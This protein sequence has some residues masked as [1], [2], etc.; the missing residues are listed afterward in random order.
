MIRSVLVFG[1]GSAGFLAAL[2]LKS[3]LPDLPV[4]VLRSKDVGIIQVGE[5]TT[6]TFGFHLHHFCGLDLKTFY[7]VAQ[8]Q[9]K[10]GIRFEWGPRTFFNYAFGVELDSRYALLP[11]GTGYYLDNTEPFD[12]TGVQSILM[13][14]NKIWLRNP[15]GSPRIVSDEFTYHLENEKLVNYFEHIAQERGIPIVD[16]TAI[17]VLQDDHG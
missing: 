2:T 4:T 16:D 9:F 7:R 14:E 8:P 1:G 3:R 15:D 13:N 12:Y 17:E 5:G 11:R 6:T 10:I